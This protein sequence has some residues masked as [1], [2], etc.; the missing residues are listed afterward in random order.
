MGPLADNGGQTMTHLPLASPPIN[1]GNPATDPNPPVSGIACPATDQRGAPRNV[2]RCDMGAVEAG[3]TPPAVYNYAPVGV[4]DGI[5]STPYETPITIPTATGL[6]ANDTDADDATF[7]AYPASPPTNGFVTINTDGS[8]TYTPQFGFSGT[9]TFTYVVCDE[10]GTC[11]STPQ[12]ASI[13]IGSIAPIYNSNP[14]TT[15]PI[16][17]NTTVNVPGSAQILVTNTGTDTLQITSVNLVGDGEITTSTAPFSITVG[18]GAVMIDLDCVSATANTF[19]AILTVVHNDPNSP[20]TYPITCTVTEIVDPP[21]PPEPPDSDPPSPP[22]IAIFDPALSKIGEL[23]PG[24][25]GLTGEQLVWTTT[26][27][28]SSG[29]VGTNIIVTDTLRSELEIDQVES[30]RG[31][32]SVS[33]QTVTVTIPVLNP[34]DTVQIRVTTTVLSS[35][36]D[37]L[38]T[39]TVQLSA[40]GNI[41]RNA[42]ATINVPIGLPDTGYP[43]Q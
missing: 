8:F 5:Y 24:Q 34:S 35:P 30:D 10:R 3:A 40:D 9:D 1:S 4:D 16:A 37:G 7:Y 2:D 39:N 11:D 29:V 33:G 25:L 28:N 23:A 26:V 27:T 12:T 20:A 42:T 36:D 22:A 21:D 18:G 6:L 38:F 41:Q 15:T 31:T 43:P 14:A 19:T 13:Q 17:I 32:V